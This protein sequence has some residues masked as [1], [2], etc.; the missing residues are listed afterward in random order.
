MKTTKKEAE[1]PEKYLQDKIDMSAEDQ[2][3]LAH[4]V[5]EVEQHERKK[6]V[7]DTVS[8]AAPSAPIKRKRSLVHNKRYARPG[9]NFFIVEGVNPKKNRKYSRSIEMSCAQL[10]PAHVEIIYEEL[11]ALLIKDMGIVSGV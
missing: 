8:V 2:K 7:E 4:I 11:E 6:Q 1:N 5:E 3:Q 10:T 9:M